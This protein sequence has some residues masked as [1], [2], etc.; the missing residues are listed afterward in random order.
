MQGPYRVFPKFIC[1]SMITEKVLVVYGHYKFGVV[2]LGFNDKC[3]N[4]LR[5][6]ANCVLVKYFIL[7]PVWPYAIFYG[8]L[9]TA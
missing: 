3:L 1:C 6:K 5:L 2:K 8:H 4:L 9:H 7:M